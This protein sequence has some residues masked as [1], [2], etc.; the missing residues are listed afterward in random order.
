MRYV[1]KCWK[2]LQPILCAYYLPKCITNESKSQNSISMIP[3]NIC[4]KAREKCEI[5]SSDAV[6][7]DLKVEE[8]EWPEFLDCDNENIFYESHQFLPLERSR[9]DVKNNGTQIFCQPLED[10]KNSDG[11]L[12]KFDVL[13]NKKFNHTKEQCLAPYFLPSNISSYEGIEGCDLNCR[14]PQFTSEERS[15]IT[16]SF[17]L[18][19]TIALI[20]NLLTLITILIGGARHAISPSVSLHHIIFVTHICC[21]LPNLYNLMISNVFGIQ[22]IS[23]QNDGKKRQKRYPINNI[24]FTQCQIQLI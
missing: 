12:N 2:K 24:T 15:L 5:I 18:I 9:N 19:A 11:N 1:P 20:F 6:A 23:C 13:W 21:I 7:S 8:N 17:F 4:L 10:L 16:R 3:K 22:K 14:S